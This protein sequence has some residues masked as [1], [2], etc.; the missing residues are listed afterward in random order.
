MK[1]S[2]V[3]IIMQMESKLVND[4]LELKKE[5]MDLQGKLGVRDNFLFNFFVY[6]S[7]QYKVCFK[8][9]CI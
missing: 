2:L 3:Y 7:R 9:L 1:E 6:I 5:N 8:L 4:G